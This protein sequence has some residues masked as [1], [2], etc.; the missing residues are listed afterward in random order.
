MNKSNSRKIARNDSW[1]CGQILVHFLY[2][3]LQILTS[4]FVR[5]E[6]HVEDHAISVLW[7]IC[8]PSSLCPALQKTMS[9]WHTTLCSKKWAHFYF[10]N[11]SIKNRPIWVMFGIQNPEEILRKYFVHHTWKMSPLYLVKC[12][13]YHFQQQHQLDM[14][15]KHEIA[16]IFFHRWKTVHWIYLWTYKII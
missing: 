6:K 9:K 11:N 10:L 16:F 14:L 7:I 8:F 15:S 3:T 12:K 4:F 13:K 1:N 5:S 2:L